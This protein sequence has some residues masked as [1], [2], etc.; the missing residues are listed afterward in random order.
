MEVHAHTHT[1]L[2]ANLSTNLPTGQAGSD[3]RGRKKWSHNFW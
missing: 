3:H 2:Y 1:G